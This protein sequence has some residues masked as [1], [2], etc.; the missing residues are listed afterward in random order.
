MLNITRIHHRNTTE[1]R[2]TSTA[3][4]SHDRYQLTWRKI[5]V[6]NSPDT[7][8][9]TSLIP[10]EGVSYHHI[11]TWSQ[12]TSSS[13]GGHI[14]TKTASR[15]DTIWYTSRSSSEILTTQESIV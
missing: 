9:R 14:L 10:F 2:C 15:R 1:H 13:S 11:K 8:R 12:A 6:S 5:S 4:D 7:T 3:V